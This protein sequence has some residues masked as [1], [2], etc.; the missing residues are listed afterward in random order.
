MQKIDLIGS[1]FRKSLNYTCL[2]TVSESQLVPLMTERAL[3]R[4][5]SVLECPIDTSVLTIVSD[6]YYSLRIQLNAQSSYLLT[7]LTMLSQPSLESFSPV[8][9]YSDSGHFTLQLKG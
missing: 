1:K 4:S 5:Q 9:L 6:D 2:I 7:H 3:Y 8:V